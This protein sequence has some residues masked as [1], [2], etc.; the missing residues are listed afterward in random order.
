MLL[1]EYLLFICYCLFVVVYLLLLF[2][3]C[4]FD[5]VYFSGGDRGYVYIWSIPHWPYDIQVAS[6]SDASSLLDKQLELVT[7]CYSISS[8]ISCVVF[9]LDGMFVLAGHKDGAVSMWLI[10]VS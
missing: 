5:V 6:Q 1:F 7:T 9:S 10:S 4:L 8:D 2:T 3:C